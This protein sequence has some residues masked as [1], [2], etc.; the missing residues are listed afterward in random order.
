MLYRLF[1]DVI[2]VVHSAFVFFV[3]F[4][5]LVVAW[6]RR[7]AWVHLPALAWGA[8][9]EFSGW[10]CPLTPLENWLRVEGGG[11]SYRGDFIS[12][13]LL[14]VLYPPALTR[15][16][17]LL[18]GALLLVLNAGVY[19]WVFRAGIAGSPSERRASTRKPS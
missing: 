19:A 2:V 10:V 18:L 8:W 11:P 12:H 16:A 7:A 17:Q 3:V 15:G 5:G 14:P 9:I 1:A 6:R 4:G 13:Y